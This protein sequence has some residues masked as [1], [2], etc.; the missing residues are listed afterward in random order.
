MSPINNNIE[1]AQSN[2]KNIESNKDNKIEEKCDGEVETVEDSSYEG[3]P[4]GPRACEDPRF[5]KFFK[6]VQ[7][8]V[9]AQAVKLKMKT[10][11]FDPNILE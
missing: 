3:E 8:G 2:V 4:S 7:F 11:G 1:S 10:E 6:M 5:M 9:P